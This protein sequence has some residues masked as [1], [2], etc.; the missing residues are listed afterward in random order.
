M[1]CHGIDFN[2]SLIFLSMLKALLG[3]IS[4]T[5]TKWI[6]KTMN[7]KSAQVPYHKSDVDIFGYAYDLMYPYLYYYIKLVYKIKHFYL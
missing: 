1:I 6:I 2:P 3:A 7:I 4:S 5:F